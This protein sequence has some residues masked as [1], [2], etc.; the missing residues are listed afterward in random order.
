MSFTWKLATAPRFYE[1]GFKARS[2]ARRAQAARN[3]RFR[4]EGGPQVRI[5][6]VRRPGRDGARGVGGVGNTDGQRGIG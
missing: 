2:F 5:D 3:D 6:D 1:A 4:E